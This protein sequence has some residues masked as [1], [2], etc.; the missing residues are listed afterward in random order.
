[1]ST[2]LANNIEKYIVNDKVA[3][4]ITPNYGAGWS[5]RNKE[6]PQMLFDPKVVSMLIT[7]YSNDEM[8]AY[9]KTT[10][11]NGY[12]SGLDDLEVSWVDVGTKFIVHDYDGYESVRSLSD[13][14]WITA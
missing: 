12:F 9:L 13:F 5:T 6:Y 11:P 4:L 8:L 2:T 3:V 1:M 14:N 7:N 10:Y